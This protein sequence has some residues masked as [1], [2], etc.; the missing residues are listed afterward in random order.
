MT[1]MMVCRIVSLQVE[2]MSDKPVAVLRIDDE[3]IIRNCPPISAR[4]RFTLDLILR[5]PE[6]QHD[7]MHKNAATANSRSLAN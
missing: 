4:K 7:L 1:K 5:S 2:F 6:T 3:V